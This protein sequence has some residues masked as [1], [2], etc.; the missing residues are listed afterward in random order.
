MRLGYQRGAAVG[1]L[2]SD[3]WPDLVVTSLNDSPRILIS[4]P[5]DAKS[6]AWLLLDLTGTSSNR[7][8]IGAKV[9]LTTESGR[10]LY[11]HVSPS[12][13]FISTSDKRV[14]FGL[15][16]DKVAKTVEITW[17]RGAVQVLTDVHCCQIVHATEPGA[18]NNKP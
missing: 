16:T 17:P 13:G 3:G 6:N 18:A 11:N 14:H 5:Q 7:D 2:N 1:D 10:H 8:A 12:V 4:N 9:K 15:G